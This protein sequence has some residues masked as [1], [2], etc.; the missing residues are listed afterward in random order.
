MAAN[1]KVDEGSHDAALK[2]AK[3]RYAE[4]FPR[5]RRI[6][7]MSL[8]L[9]RQWQLSY[10]ASLRMFC[11]IRYTNLHQGENKALHIRSP[12]VA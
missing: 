10:L 6:I 3:I 7:E 2:S 8:L 4:L 12:F 5:A 11:M 1:R 9:L